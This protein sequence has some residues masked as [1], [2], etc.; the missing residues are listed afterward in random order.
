L[1]LFLIVVLN[2]FVDIITF[3]VNIVF[4]INLTQRKEGWL[5]FCIIQWLLI[6]LGHGFEKFW[7]FLFLYS[8][9]NYVWS[10]IFHWTI[11][12]LPIDVNVIIL[13]LKLY[14]FYFILT[15]MKQDWLLIVVYYLNLLLLL[16]LFNYLSRYPLDII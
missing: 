10:L 6:N 2:W 7:L 14:L 11:N 4:F 12:K 15:Q 9:F 13:K 1:L 16:N 3:E 5:L 8:C